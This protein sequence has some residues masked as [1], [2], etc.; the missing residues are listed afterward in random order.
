[1][2]RG[3]IKPRPTNDGTLRHRV[4][5]E[6]RHHSATARTKKAAESLLAEKLRE[7]ETGA[8]VVASKETVGPYL[9]RWLK[10]SAPGWSGAVSY[11]LDS[12]VHSPIAPRLGAVPLARPSEL[13]I[14]GFYAEPPAAGVHP[15]VVQERLGHKSIAMTLD[16]YSPGC[17]TLQEKAAAL[18]DGLLGGR[19]RPR[20]GHGAG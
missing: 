14:Q 3:S 9:G 7:V 17:L 5:W 12:I 2:A 15:K 13:A 4:K 19:V 16:V 18:L 8:F 6:S 10:A 11:H 1:M 20:I